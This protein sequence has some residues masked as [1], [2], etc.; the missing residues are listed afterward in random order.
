MSLCTSASIGARHKT[1]PAASSITQHCLAI[2]RH[3]TRRHVEENHLFVYSTWGSL[4]YPAAVLCSNNNHQQ[5]AQ[6]WGMLCQQ[7]PWV[8]H[9]PFDFADKGNICSTGSLYSAPPV[10][11]VLELL[12][13]A[14]SVFSD[15]GYSRPYSSNKKNAYKHH[16]SKCADHLHTENPN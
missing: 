7:W 4:H 12:N 2:L 1:Q 10:V 11:I 14:V 15:V 3:P 8:I 6:S 9:G 13:I 5:F 16:A